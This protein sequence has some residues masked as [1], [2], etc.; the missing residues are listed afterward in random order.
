MNVQEGKCIKLA[1]QRL[2]QHKKRN[3]FTIIILTILLICILFINMIYY[4][5]QQ[6]TNSIENSIELRKIYGI[7]YLPEQYDSLKEKIEK[8]EHVEM[9][10]GQAEKRVFAVKECAQFKFAEADGTIELG[11]VNNKICPEVVKGRKLTEDDFNSIIIPSKIYANSEAVDIDN[12]ISGEEYIKGDTLLNKDIE[13]Q[14]KTDENKIYTKSFKV[15]GIFDSDKYQNTSMPYITEQTAKKINEEIDYS[16][17]EYYMEIVVDNFENIEKVED[18]LYKEKIISND[19]IINEAQDDSEVGNTQEVNFATT[20][21][22]SVQ[23]QRLIEKIMLYMLIIIIVILIA[24]LLVTNINKS[25]ISKTEIAILKVE[26]YTNKE[27]QR[28][29]IFENIIVFLISIL[30]AFIG[31]EILKFIMNYILNYLLQSDILNNMNLTTK[32]IGITAEEEIK[33]QIFY[34]LKIPQ[35]INWIFISLIT[36]ILLFIDIIN[37]YFI[38]KR[39]LNKN[40]ASILK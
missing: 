20:T 34:L 37:T 10:I 27:I 1:L 2:K 16:P 17:D 19:R 21:N 29:T 18:E 38:N 22:I 14:F 25:Y 12:P 40:I 33:E 8:I 31:F 11:V 7:R 4:S 30:L 23:T 26:G 36:V 6:Y 32:T 28:I 13:I 5:I 35:K 15:V 24:I 39:I 9:C 3:I